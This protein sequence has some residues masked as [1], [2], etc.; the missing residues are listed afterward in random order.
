MRIVFF[1]SFF[2]LLCAVVQ[3]AP[4]A[5][6]NGL[7]A[8][9]G[10]ATQLWHAASCSKT[11]VQN[12]INSAVDGDRVLI[13]AGTCTWTSRL[14]VSGKGITI[15]GAGVGQTTIVN[16]VNGTALQFNFTPGDPTTYVEGVTFDANN[17][18]NDDAMIT[19]NGGGLNQFR[20]HH[21]SMTNLRERGIEVNMDGRE[22]SGLIDHC[23]MNMPLV[24]GSSKSI[25]ISGTGP[26]ESQPFSRPLALG[27]D[28]FIFVEDCTFNYGG[29]NDGAMDA[30]GGAR[31]VFRY[32]TVIN[33]NVEHHGADSG[34]FR[35]VH[36]FEIYNNTFRCT[37]SCGS[38]RKHYFRS[39]TGVIFNNTYTGNYTGAEL[40]NYRSDESFP[41]WG[42]C[43]GTSPWDENKPGQNGYACLDQIGHVFGPTSGGANLLEPLYE[44]N[45]TDDGADVDLVV[46][47]SHAHA[48]EHI[49]QGR[50][51]YNDTRRPGYTPYRYPHPL[52]GGGTSPP[53]APTNITVTV[54]VQ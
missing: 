24:N 50:D 5:T 3:M 12:A 14:T 21:I 15:A 25:S 17:G 4:V 13:P 41:P 33:T 39:G 34:G 9:G 23:T 37:G 31:Y 49:V 52:Q 10:P 16:G 48:D 11:D 28:K 27:S 47:T 19:L 40:T 54:T 18:T 53:S 35:G 2:L 42:K 1:V 8:A 26:E 46:A 45:N 44:W 29:R 32:N 7:S 36:S 38:Q 43:D 22:V 51:F 20:V 6:I 30:Y